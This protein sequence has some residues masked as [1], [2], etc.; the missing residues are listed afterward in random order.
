MDT[1]PPQQQTRHRQGAALCWRNGTDGPEVLLIT[2][3]DTGR[4]VIPKGWLVPGLPTHQTAAREAWEEAGVK[5]VPDPDPLG[6]FAYDK[7]LAPALTVPCD[8][9]VFALAVTELHDDFPECAQRR[10]KWFSPLRAMEKVAEPGL[11]A[12]IAD[13]GHR[14]G[15]AASGKTAKP[16]AGH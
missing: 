5:G 9:T 7:R 4:W 14:A 10:R 1:A 6:Q 15:R 3:R 13:W 12:L 8:V 11:R 2:S 16:A